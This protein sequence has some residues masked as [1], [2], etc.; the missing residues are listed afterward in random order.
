M[1]KWG[2]SGG[3]VLRLISLDG[4]LDGHLKCSAVES[5]FIMLTIYYTT[6]CNV[7]CN[8]VA[9][10]H[11]RCHVHDLPRYILLL[12][13]CGTMIKC[14]DFFPLPI[15]VTAF[16]GSCFHLIVGNNCSHLNL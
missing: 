8:V 7:G 1:K 16:Y 14:T 9:S 6:E 2:W 12:L 4:S 11:D 3:Y 10:S 13:A 15:L 5:R